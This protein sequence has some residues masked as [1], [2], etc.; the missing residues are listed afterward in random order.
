MALG[1]LGAPGES[2]AFVEGP[3]QSPATYRVTPSARM[4]AKTSKAGASLTFCLSV[5]RIDFSLFDGLVVD[6]SIDLDQMRD[7]I[8][9]PS[10]LSI[11][12]DPLDESN[13]LPLGEI[14][15]VKLE[16][17]VRRGNQGPETICT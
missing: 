2:A 3:S 5:V 9:A 1:S 14:V 17:H 11:T 4:A 7:Y 15:V 13:R 10:L 16:V 12:V 6:V 8:A